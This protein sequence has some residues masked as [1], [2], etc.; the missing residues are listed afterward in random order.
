MRAAPAELQAMGF[1][2]VRAA[3]IA[4]APISA[5]GHPCRGGSRASLA[6]MADGA[7]RTGRPSRPRLTQGKD[8]SMPKASRMV[9]AMRRDLVDG[10]RAWAPS[11]P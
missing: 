10:G 9:S 4:P 11:S 7:G 2:P 6:K 1:Y 8:S 5:C 3:P